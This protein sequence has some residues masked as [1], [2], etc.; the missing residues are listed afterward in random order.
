MKRPDKDLGP[1]PSQFAIAGRMNAADI[2]VFYS[3]TEGSVALAEV[4]PPVGSWVLVG[5]FEVIQPLRLLCL[6]A[7]EKVQDEE[8]SIFDAGYVLRLEKA[9]FLRRLSRRIS[10]PVKPDDQPRDYLPTQAIADFLAGSENPPLDG[11][12]Y[13]SVQTDASQLPRIFGAARDKLNVVLFHKS[14]R[15]QELDIPED[16]EISV[17][18][19]PWFSTYG[20]MS[21]LDDES[22][23][24]YFVREQVMASAAPIEPNDAPLRFSSLEVHSVKGV[25]F[26][27]LS[28]PV[29]RSRAGEPGREVD[30]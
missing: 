17:S 29:H 25:V 14:A 15:V 7:L 5:R 12:I 28:G 8:G 22:E 20:G 10:K 27:T 9:A 26:N 24:E 13:P 18:D 6:R 11:I 23:I 21:G 2:T 19:N 30:S 3:A 16:A 4:R 1:P